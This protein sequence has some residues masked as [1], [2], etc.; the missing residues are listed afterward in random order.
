[1]S[2]DDGPT[3]P[4]VLVAATGTF[5]TAVLRELCAGLEE[6]G[7]PHELRPG[8]DDEP[9]PTALAHRIARESPLEVGVGLTERG[10][11]VH[12]A[13]LPVARP[14]TVDPDVTGEVARRMGHDAARVVTGI[15]LKFVSDEDH[16]AVG[17][18]ARRA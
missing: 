17:D 5:P 3:R 11:A 18:A 16:A 2:V 9:D 6:E 1:M 4:V 8:H 12:H 14:V 13:K 15:P 10:I 7:V